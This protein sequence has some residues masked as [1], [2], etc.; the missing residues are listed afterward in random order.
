MNASS[1]LWLAAG[2]L[3]GAS[4]TYEVMA[5]YNDPQAWLVIEDSAVIEPIE[6]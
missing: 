2:A 5:A 6:K 3:I 4:V 1:G